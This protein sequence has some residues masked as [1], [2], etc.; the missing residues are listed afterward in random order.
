MQNLK[1][2]LIG[3]P[4]VGKSSLLNSLV[5]PKVIVS[6]Y[7]G[8]T[9]E[10]IRAKKI[11]GGV[12]IEFEDTPGIYSISDRSEEEKVTERALF[13]DDI[14]GAVI[15]ADAVS[16]E[17]SLYLVFQVLEAKIPVIIALNFIESAKKKGIIIDY[18]KLAK[19]L[20]IPIIPINP[21]KKTGIKEL[22]D[23]FLKIKEAKSITF[24]VKYDDDIEIAIEEI[25]RYVKGEL[26]RRFVALRTLEEDEDYYKYLKDKS[27]IE[28]VK[29]NLKEHPKVDRDIS[30]TRY[31]TAA[32]IAE[33]ITQ[34]VYVDEKSKSLEEKVDQILLHQV[35]GPILTVLAFAMI[36]GI[37]LYLGGWIE[38]VLMD[39]V[40][41]SIL[42]AA[43]LGSGFFGMVLEAAL[44]GVMAGVSIALPYVFLFYIIFTLIEDTGFLSRFVINS[45]RFL[46]RLD[47]PGK[48]V[49]PL[50]L[51]LG[52]TVPGARATRILSS[53][54]ERFYT[55]SLFTAVPCSSRLAI[56]MGIVGH[57][58][59][60]L[61][62]VS[63]L[64]S[65][66][67]ALLVFGYFMK[68]VM[69]MEKKPVLHELP[70]LPPYR[71]PSIKNIIT[72]SWIRMKT[73]IYVVIPFLILGGIL[74][75]V[76][77]ILGVTKVIVEPFSPIMWWL[78]LPAVA[79]IPWLFSYLQKDLS[80]VMLFSVLGTE[81]AVILSPIQIYSFGMATTIGIPCMIATG[82]IWKEFG[83]RKAIIL[84]LV[85]AVYGLLF[86][87]VAFRIVSI[88]LR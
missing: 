64:A 50:A 46:R 63:V 51:G 59:G 23:A 79:I 28:K 43:R 48:A 52:C 18:K 10:V 11:F 38:E 72:K 9:V 73:F 12:K 85:S 22:I 44:T 61:L 4:N 35:W 87:G 66:V 24:T 55:T 39:L 81:I 37:L 77:D 2:L 41:E 78:G 3:Q 17:R 47:L 31:G 19:L 20:S 71:M 6:N 57:F 54:K 49:I 26:P 67:I 7:P 65:L 56:I 29:E 27:I 70:E 74:Y 83:A 25:S 34:L 80:A 84:T 62:A 68:K 16:L 21:L 14:D 82:M 45:E 58:G 5:G 36:F 86:A 76:L 69:K 88:F 8:T 40:E 15:L 1:I 32:F 13:E 60:K 53:E 30:I 42:P 75:S 33:K